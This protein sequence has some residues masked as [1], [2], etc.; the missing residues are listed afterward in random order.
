[1][2]MPSYIRFVLA[3]TMLLH[4]VSL[5]TGI[6]SMGVQAMWAWG[7]SPPKCEPVAGAAWSF[8]Q[9]ATIAAG[10]SGTVKCTAAGGTANVATV[11]CPTSTGTA[12]DSDWW[13]PC[14]PGA[15]CAQTKKIGNTVTCTGGATQKPTSTTKSASLAQRVATYAMQFAAMVAVVV[16]AHSFAG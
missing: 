3:G 8:Q 16:C 11:Q 7:T 10:S 12:P 13:G 14:G 2:Q 6:G 1:M 5:F 9:G 4:G 15:S